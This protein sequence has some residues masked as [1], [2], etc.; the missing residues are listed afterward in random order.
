MLHRAIL[1][2]PVLAREPGTKRSPPAGRLDAAAAP[3]RNS[4]RGGFHGQ[5]TRNPAGRPRLHLVAPRLESSRGARHRNRRPPCRSTKSSTT[6]A[7]RTAAASEMKRAASARRS[8]RFRATSPRSGTTTCTF[9]GAT[10]PPRSP[11][12]PRMAR[13]SAWSGSRGM[14]ACASSS[15]PITSRRP[16]VRSS[17]RSQGPAQMVRARL[18]A[19]RCGNGLELPRRQHRDRLSL[20]RSRRRNSAPCMPRRAPRRK[21]TAQALIS[22]VIAPV[23]RA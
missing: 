8:M 19:A 16:T 20:R 23:G 22:W 4:S 12:S 7:S 10:A 1:R 13:S 5:S 18:D 11:G 14:P 17:T 2:V 15:A 21:R 6:N 9:A 3:I